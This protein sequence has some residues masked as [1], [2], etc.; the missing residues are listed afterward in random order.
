MLSRIDIQVILWKEGKGYVAN[1]PLF[2]VVSQGDTVRDALYNIK[3]ALELYLEDEDVQKSINYK[4]VPKITISITPTEEEVQRA[5]GFYNEI[6][7]PIG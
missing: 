6:T 1:S 5:G 2:G 3:E 4:D 7:P